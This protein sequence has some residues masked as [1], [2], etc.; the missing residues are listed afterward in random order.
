MGVRGEFDRETCDYVGD[1]GDFATAFPCIT[2]VAATW[3]P[4]MAY[5]NGKALGRE[6]RGRGKDVSLS[7]GINIHR[8]P[9]CGRNFEYMSEDPYLLSRMCVPEIQGIQENDV[10]AC[11]KHF[12]VNDQDTNR[13][14]MLHTWA[15]EQAMRELYFKAFEIPFKEARMTIRYISDDQGTVSEK[16][17]RAATACM[18]SQNDIGA[19]IAHGNY[20]LLTGLLR[21]EWGFVGNI[22]SDM[23]VWTGDKAMFDLAFRAG[24]DTFLTYSFF[25]GSEDTESTTAHSVMRRA[26]HNV[27]YTLA[28]SALLQGSAPGSIIYYDTSPWVYWLTAVDIVVGVFAVGMIV[29]MVCRGLDERKHPDKYNRREK[30]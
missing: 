1:T 25:S 15:S 11:I 13:E 4:E 30:D 6:V 29:W 21:G 7:P 2:A 3:N 18:A 10:A 5:E 27:A 24:C 8:T 28:N 19:V 26:L 14:F 9:L 23:Y 16:T 22:H 20:A 17:M 12:A